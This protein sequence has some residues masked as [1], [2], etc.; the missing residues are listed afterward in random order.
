M[1]LWHFFEQWIICDFWNKKKL[2]QWTSK[3]QKS[4]Q[5]SWLH[6]G[7]KAE[8]WPSSL[9]NPVCLAVNKRT[10]CSSV[11]FLTE[12]LI[13]ENLLWH[14]A[15]LAVTTVTTGVMKA[16]LD[17]K[18]WGF[19]RVSPTHFIYLFLFTGLQVNWA[20]WK[21]QRHKT[22][23]EA[24]SHRRKIGSSGSESD[25]WK[26]VWTQTTSVELKRTTSR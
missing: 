20:N 18:S 4:D 26:R 10:T 24:Q 13:N 19:L 23:T 8:I 5:V 2:Q 14:K 7:N 25:G 11:V 17:W 3:R 22:F 12:R 16:N 21:I 1:F 6:V 9:S 15:A